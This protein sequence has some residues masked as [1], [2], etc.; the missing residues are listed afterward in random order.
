ME[1]I[2]SLGL[3][4]LLEIKEHCIRIEF[5]L[6]PIGVKVDNTFVIEQAGNLRSAGQI[7]NMYLH[8]YL[9]TDQYADC[10]LVL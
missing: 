10:R 9:S 5:T 2:I 3:A 1:S 6:E 8:I 7:K 4:H